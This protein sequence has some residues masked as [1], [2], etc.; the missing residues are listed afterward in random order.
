MHSFVSSYVRMLTIGTCNDTAV[1]N[2]EGPSFYEQGHLAMRQH[3][4]ERSGTVCVRLE[5]GSR[6]RPLSAR[7]LSDGARAY[8]N[9]PAIQPGEQGTTG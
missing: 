7:P 6:P 2:S 3:P 8:Q 5:H 9:P 4:Q 1:M